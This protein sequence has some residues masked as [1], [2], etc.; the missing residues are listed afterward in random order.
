MEIAMMDLD[1]ELVQNDNKA[2]AIAFSGYIFAMGLLMG[3]NLSSLGQYFDP[4]DPD[5]T[6]TLQSDEVGKSCYTIVIWSGLG[7]AL[8][9]VSHLVNDHIVMHN[10]MS[11]LALARGN[12][13]T[14]L[15]EAGFFIASGFIIGAAISGDS[16]SANETWENFVSTLFIFALSQ[17]VLVLF[18]KVFQLVTRYDQ[19]EECRKDNAAAGLNFGAHV[20]AVGMLIA[21]VIT[22]TQSVLAYFIWV[23][24]GVALI[25]LGRVLM[26]RMIIPGEKLDKEIL[27][28]Q[29]WGAALVSGAIALALAG[30][31][32]TCLRSCPYQD[33]LA[34]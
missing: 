8:L 23:V 7:L 15:S 21:K 26:D 19:L 20:V 17:A 11:L 34:V 18:G 14:A 24:L 16:E 2:V 12:I 33:C 13:A 32:N 28:D 10:Y 22:T 25:F 4:N 29:N 30:I 27:E 6:S 3:G 9:L 1:Y 31:V 5:N